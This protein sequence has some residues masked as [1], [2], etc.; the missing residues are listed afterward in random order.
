MVKTHFFQT[1]LSDRLG[2]H[3]D[4]EYDRVGLANQTP[5]GFGQ[6]KSL[7]KHRKSVN[8]MGLS[9]KRREKWGLATNSALP[10]Y[11]TVREC[12]IEPCRDR[13]KKPRSGFCFVFGDQ[14][15]QIDDFVFP[16]SLSSTHDHT[17]NTLQLKVLEEY[18][19]VSRFKYIKI[20]ISNKQTNS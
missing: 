8:K 4:L 7:K 9:R 1:F 11:T 5:H 3:T 18:C 19:E 12:L 17:S 10:Y 15:C 13:N 14:R 16:I 6:Y 2:I 20:K